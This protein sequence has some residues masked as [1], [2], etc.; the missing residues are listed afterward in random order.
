MILYTWFLQYAIWHPSILSPALYTI[1]H[2][3]TQY[4]IHTPILFITICNIKEDK[5]WE[6]EKPQSIPQH[7]VVLSNISW[8]FNVMAMIWFSCLYNSRF[9]LFYLGNGM[10]GLI[11]VLHVTVAD[12]FASLYVLYSTSVGDFGYFIILHGQ[13]W[14]K[15]GRLSCVSNTQYQ[16]FNGLVA[17]SSMSV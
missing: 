16:I 15:Y 3:S 7:C 10:E 5:Q 4:H 17:L 12:H 13:C 14:W 8:H 1:H 6:R 2:T 11:L 9:R